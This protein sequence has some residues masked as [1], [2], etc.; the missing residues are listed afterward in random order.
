METGNCRAIHDADLACLGPRRRQ[1][2]SPSSFVQ[3]VHLGDTDQH[4]MQSAPTLADNQVQLLPDLA[5]NPIRKSVQGTR[6]RSRIAARRCRALS[7]VP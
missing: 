3:S 1:S 6:Y 4:G 2:P 5:L 7:G